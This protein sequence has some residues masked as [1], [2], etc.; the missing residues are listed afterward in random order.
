MTLP[1]AIAVRTLL[2]RRV[3]AVVWDPSLVA[4]CVADFEDDVDVLEVAARCAAYMQETPSARNGPRTLRTFLER[5][6]K[7]GASKSE[8]ARRRKALAKY[9]RPQN[10]G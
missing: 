9:T 5:E 7:E 6:R 1:T 10:R 8:L 4:Q 3:P 2:A